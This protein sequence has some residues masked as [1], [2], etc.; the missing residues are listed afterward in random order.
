[1]IRAAYKQ[2]KDDIKINTLFAL[3]LAADNLPDSALEKINLA[4]E[5]DENNLETYLRKAYI[6]KNADYM[7][8]Y[9]EFVEFLY[10]K[11]PEQTDYITTSLGQY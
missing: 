4:I 1:M 8:E 10:S 3:I 7:R 5:L 2:K 6:L 11:F 9:K